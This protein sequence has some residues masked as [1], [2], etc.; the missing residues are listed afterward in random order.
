M[1]QLRSRVKCRAWAPSLFPQPALLLEE[2]RHQLPTTVGQDAPDNLGPMV[3]PRIVAQVKQAA[4]RAGLFIDGSV[5][6]PWDAGLHDGAGAHRA[7]FERDVQ[8]T[9]VQ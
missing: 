4:H 5:D 7:W 3:Q 8:R 2:L 9:A 1:Q 6:E